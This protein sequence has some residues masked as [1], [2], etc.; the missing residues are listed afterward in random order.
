MKAEQIVLLSWTSL[1]SVSRECFIFTTFRQD[2]VTLSQLLGGMLLKWCNKD[3][4]SCVLRPSFQNETNSSYFIILISM[5]MMFVDIF[6]KDS[7]T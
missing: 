5:A 3:I 7:I 2:C 1:F 4:W 6:A